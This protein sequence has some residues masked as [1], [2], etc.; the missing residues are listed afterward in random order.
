MEVESFYNAMR[1]RSVTASPLLQI[2]DLPAANQPPTNQ[3]HWS[4]EASKRERK[5]TACISRVDDKN[6]RTFVF[7]STSYIYISLK[8]GQQINTPL[9]LTGRKEV[10]V[11]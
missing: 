2:P 5:G 9:F 1:I 7:V 6:A 10:Q 4:V 8:G 3:D 11:S